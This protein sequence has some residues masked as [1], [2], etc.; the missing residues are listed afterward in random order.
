MNQM[1]EL[2]YKDIKNI[3]HLLK[4]SKIKYEHIKERQGR[5][6]ERPK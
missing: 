4:K 5:Y 2:A 6:L 3:S 1:K